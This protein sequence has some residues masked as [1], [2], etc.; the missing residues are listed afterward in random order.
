MIDD[1]LYSEQFLVFENPITTAAGYNDSSPVEGISYD[2]N[3]Y[4]FTQGGTCEVI[5]V[6]VN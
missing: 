5:S 1:I 6:F 4:I 2:G 3:N